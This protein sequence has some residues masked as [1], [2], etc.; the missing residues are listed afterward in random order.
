MGKKA[1]GLFGGGI[2]IGLV[3]TGTA[4]YLIRTNH[5]DID[6]TMSINALHKQASDGDRSAEKQ[7]FDALTVS[8]RLFAGHKIQ[9]RDDA[10]EVVQEAL[11]VIARRYQE[12]EFEVSFAAWANKVLENTVL[13]YYR[14][15]GVRQRVFDGTTDGMDEGASYQVDPMLKARLLDCLRE[16]SKTRLRHARILTL[17]FQGFTVAEICRRLSITVNNFY[18]TLMRA[19]N[20]LAECLQKGERE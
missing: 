11:M 2:R 12:I 8:F 16:V 14:S 19:R 10:E 1:G 6:I 7:L 13:K 20:L 9:N 5:S 17:H 18:V 4:M 15:K 3:C